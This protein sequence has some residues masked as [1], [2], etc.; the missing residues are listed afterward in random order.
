MML[1]LLRDPP[2]ASNIWHAEW[3]PPYCPAACRPGCDTL[4]GITVYLFR[5]FP[6]RP[7]TNPLTLQPEL[8]VPI[9]AFAHEYYFDKYGCRRPGPPP[10]KDNP[11]VIA[12]YA[13]NVNPDSVRTPPATWA[14]VA[15]E[16]QSRG[17][18]EPGHIRLLAK[19][20]DALTRL[21][22]THSEEWV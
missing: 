16:L 22:V 14:L 1:E 2:D 12:F 7:R 8:R 9:T 13:D 10:R 6:P 20:Q 15:E 11:A 19:W 4:F 18:P 17:A 5:K 21:A 3:I